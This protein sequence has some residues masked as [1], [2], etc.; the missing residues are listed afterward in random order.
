MNATHACSPAQLE[1]DLRA[2]PAL[3]R[4]FR[5]NG[6]RAKAL[7][8]AA[9]R[10]PLPER[11]IEGL[12]LWRL[13]RATETF[14]YYRMRHFARK[15]AEA[16]A[17]LRSV[18][19]AFR[20]GVAM[21]VFGDGEGSSPAMREAIA[22]DT[23]EL[24]ARVR[25]YEGRAG[26]QMTR[27]DAVRSCGSAVL[28]VSCRMC[29]ESLT[30]EPIPCRCGV[31][32]VCASCAEEK[33]QKRRERIAAARERAIIE[34]TAAGVM[35]PHRRGG[36]FSE[37]MLTLTVPHFLR[38]ECREVYDDAGERKKDVLSET[39]GFGLNTDVAARVAALRLAWPRFVRI[40]RR[41]LKRSDP[42]GAKQFA[43][44][45]FFEWT[46]GHDGLG[47]PHFHVYL[48]SPWLDAKWLARVW[49]S[50]LDAVGAPLPSRCAWCPSDGVGPCAR[51]HVSLD[52]RMLYGFN[53]GTLREL[54]KSGDRKLVVER[55]GELWGADAPGMAPVRYMSGW[56]MADA[57]SSLGSAELEA[58][59]VNVQRDLFIATEGRR[60]W[61]GARGFLVPLPDAQCE[62]CGAAR[63]TDRHGRTHAVFAAGV[64]LGFEARD[65]Y[66]ERGPP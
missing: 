16:R 51:A 45:R 30:E 6:G 49:A 47:H 33:D 60:L 12:P 34:G 28:N 62:C 8:E 37:K 56:K 15:A 13:E 59:E 17:S 1:S 64:V 57:F 61:Q 54:V 42:E 66:E 10:E 39:T 19:D 52:I 44:Y 65:M 36:A 4:S 29:R 21:G 25:W 14:R 41:A 32:R 9:R 23:R 35:C 27:F 43:Y 20:R 31:A 53:Y 50:C 46:R 55:L 22:N 26:A 11:Q 5:H 40:V 58:D 3:R 38:D 7:Q 24:A 18:V 2:Y 48:F 63:W